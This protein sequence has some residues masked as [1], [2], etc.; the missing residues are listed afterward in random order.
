MNSDPEQDTTEAFTR[1]RLERVSEKVAA[2][3]KK[4]IS[5]GLF[6]VGARLPAERE[7]AELM[8]VSRASVR[9]A[10]QMLELQ[11][12]VETVHGGG[13]IVR[14]L[15]EQ[16]IRKPI[17][18]LLEE[19]RQRVLEITEVRAFME[20]WGAR[21]AA[22]NRGEDDLARI[23]FFLQEMEKDLEKGRIRHEV[24][25]KFHIEIA[26]STHN[27]FFLHL[28]DSVH[29]LISYSVKFHREQLFLTRGDQETILGHHR[30]IF[31]SV[32]KGDPPAAEA[33]MAEHLRFV[34]DQFRK[35]VLGG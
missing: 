34:V 25:F 20:A 17:E 30:R 10:I 14:N 29:Q 26:G 23:R 19:D 2:Q 11:G 32:E 22:K 28:M 6:K 15:T 16:E 9:E 5:E 13:S 12:L 3:L 18:I 21:E 33:A 1:I 8:G 35:R 7:L 4:V 24:D 27:T 31:R